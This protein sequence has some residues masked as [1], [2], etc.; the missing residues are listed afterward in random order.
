M[1]LVTGGG[2]SGC[3]L[4]LESQEYIG[5]TRSFRPEAVASEQKGHAGLKLASAT[6]HAMWATCTD[7]CTRVDMHTDHREDDSMWSAITESRSSPPPAVPLCVL[8][9]AFVGLLRRPAP[10]GSD[11]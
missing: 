9:G 7:A 6:I 2:I 3:R 11:G 1:A 4:E 5:I 8:A 10:E